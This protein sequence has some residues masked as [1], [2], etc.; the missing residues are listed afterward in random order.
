MLLTVRDS[1]DGSLRDDTALVPPPPRVSD[2]VTHERFDLHASV[3]LDADDSLGRE[4]L[5]RYLTRPSFSLARLRMRRDGNVSYR[6]KKVSRGRV[7]ERVMTPVDALGCLAAIVPP[8][9]YP[10]LRFH[11]VVAPR[12]RWRARIVPQPPS[13]ASACTGNA[14][15]R[16]DASHTLAVPP[17]PPTTPASS[18]SHAGDGRAVFRLDAHAVPTVATIPT[19]ATSSLTTTGLAEQ[20]APNVLLIAHWE[21]LLEGELYASSSRI[22]WRTLLK[23]TFDVDLRVCVRCGGR[24][25]IRAVVTET[26][27]V[28]RLLAALRHPRAPPAAA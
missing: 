22:D 13:S 3:H 9:R 21:R 5:C 10:L 2:A 15:G 20:V 1:D 4:R 24:L 17:G 19:I 25:E 8:P 7:T 11:G 16:G 18:P 12:H 27:S 28:A 26:A 14:R 6:V 23:R